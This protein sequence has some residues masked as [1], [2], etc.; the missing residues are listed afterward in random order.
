MNDIQTT[1][2]KSPIGFIKIEGNEEVISSLEFVRRRNTILKTPQCL[3]VY[4]RQLDEYFKGKRK[5]FSIKLNLE[6]T[7]FQ[8]M[9]WKELQKIPYGKTVSYKYIAKSVGNGKAQRAI[10]NANNKNKVSI[11]VPC[12]RV[13]GSNGE[14][15]GYGGGLWRK[16]WLIEFEEQHNS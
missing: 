4:V 9:V 5:I 1:Y 2:F 11:I 8:V 12:H 15:T 6:G 14:L 7:K 16:K 13:I 3:K 10:G